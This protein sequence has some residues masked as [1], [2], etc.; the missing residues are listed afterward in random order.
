MKN[1]RDYIEIVGDLTSSQGNDVGRRNWLKKLNENPFKVVVKLVSE[2]KVTQELLE[3][4]VDIGALEIRF[5]DRDIPEKPKCNGQFNR[6]AGEIEHH[7]EL[8][9]PIHSTPKH[10]HSA[11]DIT[12]GSQWMK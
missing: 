11:Q 3:R 7:N 10:T 1:Y 8:E 2:D 12:G 9:C 5:P 6:E 4:V